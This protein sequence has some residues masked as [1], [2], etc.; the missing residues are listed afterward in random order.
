LPKKKKKRAERVSVPSP[1]T[2]VNRVGVVVTLLLI[3]GL[4]AAVVYVSHTP[5]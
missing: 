5:R 3:A 2:S 1:E 4:V